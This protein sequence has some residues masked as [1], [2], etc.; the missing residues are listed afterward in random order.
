[1][2]AFCGN[3]GTPLDP[4]S[5]FCGSC[6]QKMN[7][8]G[9]V[10]STAAPPA[11]FGAVVKVVLVLLGCLVVCGLLGAAGLYFAG[12]QAQK[13]GVVPRAGSGWCAGQDRR[14]CGA[15]LGI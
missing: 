2:N 4:A 10:K 15:Q 8:S 12:R 7:V 14:K 13:K 1:M 3:C 6:G 5:S 11:K 9:P